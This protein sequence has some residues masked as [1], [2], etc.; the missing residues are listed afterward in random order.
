[1][2][3]LS[4]RLAHRPHRYLVLRNAGPPPIVCAC[5]AHYSSSLD[6]PLM[7]FP[8]RANLLEFAADH[9]D[10]LLGKSCIDRLVHK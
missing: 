1:M 3:C 7:V 5:H 10:R 4:Q 6:E 9:L 8:I 2:L